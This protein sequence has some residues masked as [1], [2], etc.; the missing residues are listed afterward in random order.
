[1]ELIEPYKINLNENDI[2][3]DSFEFKLI[4]MAISILNDEDLNV[5]G[6][7]IEFVNVE[8]IIDKS[9]LPVSINFNSINDEAPNIDID[10]SKILNNSKNSDHLSGLRA[11][12]ISL[13]LDKEKIEILFG[14]IKETEPIVIFQMF[15]E[16]I[17]V[18]E[19]VE[20]LAFLFLYGLYIEEIVFNQ[21][22]ALD[23]NEKKIHL[24]YDK[25][26]TDFDFIQQ[27]E[28]LHQKYRGITKIFKNFPI[29]IEDND[30]LL[31]IKEPYFEDDKFICPYIK[32]NLSDEQKLSL[33]NFLYDQWEK[34]DK[35]NEIQNIDW[36]IINDIETE[37][38]LGFNPNHSVFPSKYACKNES[39]Y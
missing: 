32:E 28:I 25:Y 36:S 2:T 22:K 17:E 4:K 10:V 7:K 33:V 18:I 15:S 34:N 30:N 8:E 19:N 11:Q 37:I 27:S 23:V 26:L 14:L 9:K 20:Q 5:F 16:N 29:V 13:G 21:F 38:I 31:L 24:G 35:K 3:Q 1:M 12:F 39:V 6:E